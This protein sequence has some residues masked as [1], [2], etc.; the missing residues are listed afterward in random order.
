MKFN[1]LD[2]FNPFIKLCRKGVIYDML[3]VYVTLDVDY[4]SFLLFNIQFLISLFIHFFFDLS[5]SILFPG[6]TWVT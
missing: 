3:I 2:K 6:S 1:D 5:L 4:T